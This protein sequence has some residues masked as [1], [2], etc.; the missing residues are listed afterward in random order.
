MNDDTTKTTGDKGTESKY[1]TM[2]LGECAVYD[3]DNHLREKLTG[4]GKIC[5]ER[6]EN[7]KSKR[8]EARRKRKG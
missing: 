7:R 4:W 2:S 1:K 6:G 8:G 3:R 5:K